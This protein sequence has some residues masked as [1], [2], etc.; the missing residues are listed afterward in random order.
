MCI[1]NK[2]RNVSEAKYKTSTRMLPD[3]KQIE[4]MIQQKDVT[5]GNDLRIRA[6]WVKEQGGQPF[7]VQVLGEDADL[8]TGGKYMVLLRE[9]TQTRTD[10][11]RTFVEL[12]IAGAQPVA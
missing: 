1:I 3:L 11:G 5:V 12:Q 9:R 6:Y 10:D 2:E 8:Q 7:V 4:V